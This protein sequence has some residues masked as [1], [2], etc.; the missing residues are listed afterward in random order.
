MVKEEMERLLERRVEIEI[1]DIK[2]FRNYKVTIGK[3]R[4][5]LGFEPSRDVRDIIAD[6]HA[7]RDA[8][9]DLDDD[10]YYNIRVFRQMVDH[11]WA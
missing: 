1:K 6:L 9:G 5:V 10:R 7:H 3:A 11:T 4:T 2:D 8:Y